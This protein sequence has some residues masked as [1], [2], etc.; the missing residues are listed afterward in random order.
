MKK[1]IPKFLLF[2]IL[3]L[4][5]KLRLY[6][7]SWD[8]GYHLHPDERMLIM[9]AEKINFFKNL[10][11]DFFNYG[12]LPLYL[13]KGTAQLVDFLF[14]KNLANY[15]GMLKVGRNLSIFFDLVTIVF[16][17]KISKLLFNNEKIALLSSL[18]YTIAFFAIQNTHFFVVDVPLNTFI[19]ILCYTLLKYTKR[20]SFII[21]F[22]IGIVFAAMMS[23]KFTSII[24][25]PLILLLFAYKNWGNWKNLLICILTFHLSFIIFHYLTMP[26]AFIEQVRFLRDI[27]E[28][29]KMN[30]NPY[31]FPYTLQYVGTIPYIYYLKNIFLW[32]LGPFISILSIIG[33]FNLFQFSIFNFQFSLKSK[34][35][36]YKYLIIC[37]FFYLYYFIVI[38][39][40]AVKFMRYMLPLYPFLTILAGYGLFSLCHPERRNEMT[41]TKDLAKRKFIS[42][43]FSFSRFLAIL[44]ITGGVLWTYMFVNIYS[45]EHT[46]ITASD[47]ISKNIKEGATIATEHW[48]DGMP[49]Y[50]GEKYKHEELTLYDQPD[51]VNKWLVMNEKLKNSDY[52]IIASNRLYTP[53]RKLSDCQKYRSCFPKTADYYKKLFS[54]QLPFR[55]VVELSSYPQLTIGNYQLSIPD[56]SADESFT[57]YDHPKILIYKKIN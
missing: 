41:E 56:D 44:G 55:K 40:S 3:F 17:H 31:I 4:A 25:Y 38:G 23:T 13:L 46:R 9:V 15:D 22:G 27:K 57:V 29:L 43:L 34:F 51:D 33:L 28:Q 36:N 24:F 52:I 18:F 14:N 16:I 39:Q 48:D 20:S 5:Y 50:G 10:N 6:G 54:N 8:Q 26:Y 11:P 1:Q 42:K 19:T 53:L 2:I 21:V 30:S 49:L 7:L 35:I 45:V 32:G 12:S 37:L 47:W